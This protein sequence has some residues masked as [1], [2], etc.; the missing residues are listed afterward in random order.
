MEETA[1]EWAEDDC[2][3]LL[4]VIPRM[5]QRRQRDDGYA[6]DLDVY[7][8]TAWAAFLVAWE[9]WQTT[10][11]GRLLP[12]ATRY[13]YG[14]LRTAR[15]DWQTW[16]ECRTG[17]A[18]GRVSADVLRPVVWSAEECCTALAAQLLAT[19]PPSQQRW[20][21]DAAVFGYT[22]QEH[23]AR[24]GVREQAISRRRH[25]WR[26]HARETLQPGAGR[27]PVAS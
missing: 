17:Q 26:R 5:A 19:L 10:A 15:R 22:G 27:S 4:R 20:V 2:A 16:H 18:H 1:Q 6:L 24:E 9:R 25:Q 3:V 8:D 7:L 23:A 11:E 14:R 13:I 21:I 12:S